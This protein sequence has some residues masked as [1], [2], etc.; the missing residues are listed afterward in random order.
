MQSDTDLVIQEKGVR[1]YIKKYIENVVTF[2]TKFHFRIN[3]FWRFGGYGIRCRYHPV[4]YT[5]NVFNTRFRGVSYISISTNTR[6][7]DGQMKIRIF[8]KKIDLFKLRLNWTIL[9]FT[10]K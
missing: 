4:H 6:Q 8:F 5:Y 1:I 3:Q 7:I 9:S 10:F 2:S